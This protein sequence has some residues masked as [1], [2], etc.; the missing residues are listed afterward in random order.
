VVV[1]TEVAIVGAGPYGLSLAAHL[2]SAGADFRVI[3]HPM[4]AWRNHMPEGMLLKSDGFASNLYDPQGEYPLSR[5]CREL[6]IAYDDK[7]TRVRL[8]T[9]VDYGLAFARRFVPELTVALVQSLR[10]E[11]SGFELRLDDGSLV[12]ARRIVVAVGVGRFKNIPEKLRR[13]GDQVSHSYDHRDLSV[14]TGR[15]IAVVGAGASA[16]DIAGL[17]RD[18]DAD[19]ELICRA[20][21]LGFGGPRREND[22]SLWESLRNPSSGIGPG[23][24]SRLCTDATLLFYMGPAPLRLKIVEKHLGPF[25]DFVMKEKIEGRVPVRNGCEIADT[26]L[27]GGRIRLTL[28]KRD[29][30]TSGQSYDHVVA[31]TGYRVDIN[32]LEFLDKSL[33]SEIACVKNTPILSTRFQSS[34]RGLFFV[35][36]VAANSFGPMMRFAYGAGF[37]SRRV[38]GALKPRRSFIPFASRSLSISKL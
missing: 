13:L 35:G 5:H 18:H 12:M 21:R 23:W 36:P 16:I 4:E 6:G 31:G 37:A 28:R 7:R 27:E 17:M 26:A 15:R 14:F 11:G 3:G 38:A 34:V 2:R 32:R 20:D 33:R 30:T 1:K 22:P 29:G 8:D 19:V 10:R 24:P 9:F 25:A